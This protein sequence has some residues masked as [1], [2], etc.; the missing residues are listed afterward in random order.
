MPSTLPSV[1]QA[2][3]DPGSFDT[4]LVFPTKYA[5]PSLR[6]YLVVHPNSALGREFTEHHDLSPQQVAAMLGGRVEKVFERNGEW[7]AVLRFDRSYEAS[8][9]QLPR[10][11]MASAMP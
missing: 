6:R 11:N 1:Q 2:A 5:S 4:A 10:R 7:A 9:K 8:L 3:Q